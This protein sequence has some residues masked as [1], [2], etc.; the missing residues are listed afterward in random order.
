VRPL[1]NVLVAAVLSAFAP[2]VAI[3]GDSPWA[4]VA[5]TVT[6]TATDGAT[7]AGEGARVTLACVADAMTR[8]EVSD[9]HGAFRFLNVPVDTCLIEA[10]VQGFAAQTMRVITAADE[11][12]QTDLRLRIAPLRVGVSLA[13]SVL[14]QVPKPLRKSRQSDTRLRLERPAKGCTR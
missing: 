10:D 4:T 3:A 1:H 6:L 2:V 11:V 7:F 9:E 13:G 8:T 12:A 14:W 5:G